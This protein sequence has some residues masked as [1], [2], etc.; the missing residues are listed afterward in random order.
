[1]ENEN[2]FN[3]IKENLY[4]RQ[5]GT[6]GEDVMKRIIN[7]NILILGLKGLGIEI[8]KN[9]ILTGPKIVF[10]YDADITQSRDLGTNYYL[11]KDDINKNRIDFSCLDS[12]SN[13]NQFTK[14]EVLNIKESE[15]LF[16]IIA[17]KN[18]DIIVQTEII[19]KNEIIKLNEFCR[20]NNIKFIY[21]STLGLS[22]FIFSDFGNNH[23][24]Y[25][26]YGIE[27]QK[28]F[29]QD[30]TNS[31]RGLVSVLDQFE[32]PF[33]LETGDYVIFK[34]VKGMIE[35]NDNRPRKITI[36]DDHSFFIE[37]DTSNYHKF[38]GN[39]DIYEHRKPINKSYLS[40]K[41][42]IEIPFIRKVKSDNFTEQEENKPNI[43]SFFLSIILG[44]EEY[45][46]DEN[47]SI[48]TIKNEKDIQEIIT[49]SE[50]IFNQILE[51]DRK[52]GILFEGSEENEIQNFDKN[53]AF[54]IIKYSQYN[55][56][57]I[58]SMIGG[59]ISQEIMK[60][61][62][63]YK[64][65]NQWIF[66]DLYDHNFN[67]NQIVSNEIINNKYY[68]QISIFGSKIQEKLQKLN[69]F[70]AGAGA[71]GCELLKN[72]AL[73]GISMIDQGLLTISDYDNIEISNLNRQFLFNN[74]N[75]GQSKSMVACNEIKKINNDLNCKGL[76]YKIG[77]ETEY[78]F[79]E[80]FWKNQDIIISAVD[81]DEAREYLNDK[82]FKYNKLLLNIGTSGVRAKVDIVI[83][84]LTYPLEIE[85]DLNTIDEIQMCTIKFYPSKIEHCIEWSNC[86]FHELFCENIKIFNLFLLNEEEFIK[87]MKKDANEI[88]FE[89][90]QK[91]KEIIDILNNENEEIMNYKILELSVLYFYRLYI[92]SIQN[93]L[94]IHPPDKF[95]NG[96]WF[97]SGLKKK[98][99]AFEVINI[100]DK[101]TRQF[102]YSF[103]FILS[104][105]LGISFN[106]KIFQN[107]NELKEYIEKIFNSIKNKD[108]NF[109]DNEKTEKINELKKFIEIINSKKIKNWEIKEEIFSKDSLSNNH[110]EFIQ[111]SSNLRARN[112]G[113]EES[114]KNKVLMISGKI[115]AAVPTSTA[116][117][118]GYACLQI[119]N[120]MYSKD[121][122]NVI[123]NAF[124]NLGLNI[125]D[126]ISPENINEE[127]EP[128]E[129]DNSKNDYPNIEINGS[130]TIK[131]FLEYMKNEYNLE[132]YHF[133][134]NEKILYDKR[135]TKDPRIIKRELEKSHKKIEEVYFKQ[136]ED[137]NE[138]LEELKNKVFMIKI[139]C[140]AKNK[141]TNEVEEIYNYPLI[142]YIIK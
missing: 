99:C 101:M 62:G 107:N 34:N 11:K 3:K 5:I 82:C 10:I 79:N 55:I 60:I 131:E 110:I 8:A 100:D 85:K 128:D 89:K 104:H 122:K 43:N 127:E 21:G 32:N 93:L 45:L 9:I 142:K 130:K 119:I 129:K 24:I 57:P 87:K 39:G 125:F 73:M 74:K 136:I 6:Y 16:N 65:L 75:I 22:G 53:I 44:L 133:E 27:P 31:I 86:L 35:L 116:S 78:I 40:F 113:I 46:N 36:N 138:Y 98:P 71:V 30:I 52:I 115:I 83:P 1:M 26:Q 108:I 121:I 80:E 25:D 84:N 92:K 4:S 33:R 135:V 54:H 102:L 97:W 72:L 49:K 111:S 47:N 20:K 69:I 94:L 139:Y 17:T 37:D 59:Y 112:Y 81:S 23:I 96:Q 61:T 90:Y 63:K 124:F 14:V 64:P 70:I 68:D 123:K 76:I 106:K 2:E 141:E 7:L 12:L 103:C 18:L 140:R 41:Q 88:F 38:E 56:I 105:C 15:N 13:L 132:I 126:L 137:S 114:N 91:I 120:L 95:E 19:S 58:C 51:N 109:K 77:K 29:C 28:F 134:I 118:V 42:N 66:F 48:F 50:I 117:I 67:Y